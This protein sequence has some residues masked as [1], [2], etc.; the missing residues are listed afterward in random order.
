MLDVSLDII[1][2]KEDAGRSNIGRNHDD[3]SHR[4][5]TSRFFKDRD[6]VPFLVVHR[7]WSRMYNKA[8]SHHT[9]GIPLHVYASIDLRVA[10]RSTLGEHDEER[11]RKVERKDDRK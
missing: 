8:R 1:E 9:G 2:G 10:R 4:K 3:E 7:W 11:R 6:R 5:R